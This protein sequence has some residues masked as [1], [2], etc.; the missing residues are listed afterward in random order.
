[1]YLDTTK[2]DCYWREHKQ[3]YRNGARHIY[4]APYIFKGERL[5]MTMYLGIVAPTND[6]RFKW[7]RLKV[8]WG[9]PTGWQNGEHE[10]G[11]CLTIA[12]AK[13]HI[14]AGFESGLSLDLQYTGRD[15]IL[16]P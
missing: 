9:I 7:T 14:E 5:L 13:L 11:C 6:G 16:Y 15:D 1:M 3:T 8:K 4:I 10:Q 2:S 12:E